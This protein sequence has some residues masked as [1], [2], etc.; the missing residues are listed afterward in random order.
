MIQVEIKNTADYWL[1]DCNSKYFKAAE[2]AIEQEWGIKPLYIREG[3]SIPAVRWLE[4]FCSA[5]AVH[6]PMGQVSMLLHHTSIRS[7]VN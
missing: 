1:G 4:R 6:L 3:G 7:I 2:R 5:P